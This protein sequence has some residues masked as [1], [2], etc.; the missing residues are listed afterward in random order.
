MWPLVWMTSINNCNSSYSCKIA[1]ASI[2]FV[3]LIKPP[4]F[5]SIWVCPPLACKAGDAR[6]Y[7]IGETFT[8]A[9]SW[10]FYIHLFKDPILTFHVLNFSRRKMEQVELNQPFPWRKYMLLCVFFWNLWGIH[11]QTYNMHIYMHA[12]L[13]IHICVYACICMIAHIYKIIFCFV[14]YRP[15]FR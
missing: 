4:K 8:V 6:K 7:S 1:H 11:T 5:A 9:L 3:E 2:S 15:F 13:Y 14:L 10:M 12:C